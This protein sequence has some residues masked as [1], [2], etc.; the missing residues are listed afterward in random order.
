[1]NYGWHERAAP[2][3]DAGIGQLAEHGANRP[4]RRRD[5]AASPPA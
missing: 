2:I 5:V 3:S 4:A 1:M